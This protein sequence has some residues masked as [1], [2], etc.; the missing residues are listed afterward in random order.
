MQ[1]QWTIFMAVLIAYIGLSVLNPIMAP[2]I[3]ALGLQET[4]AGW[5]VSASSLMVMLSSAM[6]GALSDKIGRKR[7]ILIGMTGMV[8]SYG[9]FGFASQEGLAGGLPIIPL[10]VLLLISRILL[11]AS[12][13]AILSASQAYM[14]DLTSERDRS[15]GMSLI[16]AANGIGFVIGPALAAVLSAIG[17][18]APIYVA[19]IL[20]LLALI[21]IAFALPNTVSAG[22]TRGRQQQPFQRRAVA[23]FLVVA[24]VF[25]MA[26]IQIQMTAGFYFQ[27]KLGLSTAQTAQA[28]GVA[29]LCIGIMMALVQLVI[30]RAYKL[31][32]FQLLRFGVPIFVSGILLLISYDHIGVYAAAF[33]LLGIGAGLVIPGFTSGASLA[34]AQ[35][36]QGAAAGMIAMAIGIGSL[37]GPL[38]GTFLYQIRPEVPF[39]LLIVLLTLLTCY[40]WSSPSIKKWK[41]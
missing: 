7:V 40:I 35:H 21:G 28:V 1:P 18:L 34:V 5:I 16:G 30:V 3:R 26:L 33:A 2:L 37:I 14:A 41:S 6:W 9:M 29:L 15:A 31:S 10:F 24:T 39:W 38:S 17:F 23:P 25:M 27:D 13:P 36:E 11:G 20:P 19:A 32:P 12:F 4:D 22:P 8:I